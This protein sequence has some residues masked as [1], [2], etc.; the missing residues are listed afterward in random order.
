MYI[1]AWCMWRPE[2]DLG[3]PG[4]GV[5]RI[6]SLRVGAKNQTWSSEQLKLLT[7]EPS[8]QATLFPMNRKSWSFAVVYM[9]GKV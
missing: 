3:F 7:Y 9:K 5:I 1:C 4:T 2:E 8:V 6:V